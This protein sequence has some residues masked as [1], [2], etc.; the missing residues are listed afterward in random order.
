MDTKRPKHYRQQ[1]YDY[2]EELMGRPLSFEE[3]DAL[4]DMIGEYVFSVANMRAIL[5]RVF[6]AHDW[7]VDKKIE[8]GE[9]VRL[10]VKCMKCDKRT[11]KKMPTRSMRV[12]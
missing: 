10:Y 11:S 8:G 12:G 9:R 1:I 2:I 5:S 6:C 4:R 7:K 3:H